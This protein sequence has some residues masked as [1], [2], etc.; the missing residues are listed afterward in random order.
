MKRVTILSLLFF[1]I[2]QVNCCCWKKKINSQELEMTPVAQYEEP[3]KN[4]VE[5][6]DNTIYIKKLNNLHSSKKLT[7]SLSM[8]T[9]TEIDEEE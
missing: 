2:L 5:K 7:R 4:P 6:S 3:T 9:L 8:Q 1:T